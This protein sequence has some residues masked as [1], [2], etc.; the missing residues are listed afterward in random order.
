MLLYCLYKTFREAVNKVRHKYHTHV[1]AH[2]TFQEHTFSI[3]LQIKNSHILNTNSTYKALANARVARFHL[4]IFLLK[5]SLIF[6][7]VAT[8]LNLKSLSPSP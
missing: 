2:N 6:L 1:K 7:F 8:A 3:L 4:V 5:M